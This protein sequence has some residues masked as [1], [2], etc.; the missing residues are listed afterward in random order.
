MVSEN[1]EKP[2]KSRTLQTRKLVKK[3]SR[4][5]HKNIK[6][7]GQKSIDLW[8]TTIPWFVVVLKS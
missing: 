2:S 7:Q 3:K 5:G 4:L 8:K 6:N 1:H